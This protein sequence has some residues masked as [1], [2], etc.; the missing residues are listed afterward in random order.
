MEEGQHSNQP[1][2]STHEEKESNER[3]RLTFRTLDIIWPLVV[4]ALLFFGGWYLQNQ[5]D[6]TLN[7][8]RIFGA[9]LLATIIVIV[10]WL[11]RVGFNTNWIL[12]IALVLGVFY[13]FFIGKWWGI[14]NS[15]GNNLTMGWLPTIE[16]VEA[17]TYTTEPTYT[18]RP[19]CIP[20]EGPS[21]TPEITKAANTITPEPT[22]FYDGFVNKEDNPW[23]LTA[24]PYYRPEAQFVELDIE[25]GKL[26]VTVDCDIEPSEYGTRFESNVCQVNIPIPMSPRENFDIRFTA[27]F[28]VLANYGAVGVTTKAMDE[29]ESLTF[30]YTTEPAFLFVKGSNSGDTD[31]EKTPEVYE[32]NPLQEN[33]N[34]IFISF[35]ED[36]IIAKVNGKEVYF[37]GGRS[38][39][40]KNI[41]SLTVYTVN[42]NKIRVLF[43]EL[44]VLPNVDSTDIGAR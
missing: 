2:S 24:A 18:L 19:S 15:P 5:W 32:I 30:L 9:F 39:T 23:R 6:G 11:F 28:K 42:N 3:R 37:N 34:D 33:S 22:Y 12:V 38:I 8:F 1:Q 16:H 13:S 26:D 29:S 17:P 36:K 14:I 10:I 7:E 43:D 31:T 4:E 27:V 40:G 35:L 21:Q 25:D 20:T 41:I 44:Y